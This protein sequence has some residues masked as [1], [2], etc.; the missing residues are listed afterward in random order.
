MSGE[1][2]GDELDVEAARVDGSCSFLNVHSWQTSD[3]LANR[4]NCVLLNIYEN[5]KGTQNH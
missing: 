1:C 3:T 5:I 2:V 4:G